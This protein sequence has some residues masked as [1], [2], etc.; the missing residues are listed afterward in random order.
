MCPDQLHTVSNTQVTLEPDLGLLS[1][2]VS[3]P[4]FKLNSL[5]AGEDVI[6]ISCQVFATDRHHA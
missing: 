1:T 3:R 5:I 6:L 4:S 2:C